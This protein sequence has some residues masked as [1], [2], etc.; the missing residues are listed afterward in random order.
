[1]VVANCHST[2]ITKIF[3]I[4]VYIALS[5]SVSSLLIFN[6]Y[7]QQ[8]G[9]ATGGSTLSGPAN[10][11]G[12]CIFNG[13]PAIGGQ[14]K[15]GNTNSPGSI[16]GAATGGTNKHSGSGSNSDQGGPTQLPSNLKKIA[17]TNH[18]TNSHDLIA[19]GN[20]FSVFGLYNEAI[21]YHD[22]ALAIDPKNAVTL[23]NKDATIEK[24]NNRNSQ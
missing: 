16:E 17:C 10:C 3:L 8:G 19:N 4:S 1:M 22:K 12:T 7:A 6:V 11:Y 24:L 20:V 13:P 18:N 14:D 2:R 23:N 15:G 21:T 9:A 5:F